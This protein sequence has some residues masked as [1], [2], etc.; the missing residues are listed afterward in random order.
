MATNTL[1]KIFFD[2]DHS[3][4]KINN[5]LVVCTGN[6]C[7]SPIAEYF[8]KKLLNDSTI[9]VESAGTNAMVNFPADPN[10]CAVM[11]ARGYD[12]S[13]HRAKQINHSLIAR[14][15]LVLVM[16]RT[17]KPWIS[18]NFPQYLGRVFKLGFWEA[19]ADISDPY[20][21]SQEHFERSCIDIEHHVNSWL[22]RLNKQ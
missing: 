2:N 21:R 12:L 11:H 14:S 5:I 22:K 18:L 17:H 10:S 7:R 15:D 13:R 8:L 6:I 16:D 9:V 20:G 1:R 3:S 4:M 19:D